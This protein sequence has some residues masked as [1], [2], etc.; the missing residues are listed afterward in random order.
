MEE[1]KLVFSAHA[2]SRMAQRA[3]SENQVRLIVRGGARLP[4]PAAETSAIRWRYSGRTDGRFLTVI[5]AQEET[6]LIVITAY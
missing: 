5:V 2:H 6:E 1:R 3:I 4:E